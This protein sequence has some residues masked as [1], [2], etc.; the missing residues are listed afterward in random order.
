V[1]VGR[2]ATL[3]SAANTATALLLDSEQP[4]DALPT[5]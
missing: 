5:P 3:E 1:A 4:P 2:G